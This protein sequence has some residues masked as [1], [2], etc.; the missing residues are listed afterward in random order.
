MRIWTRSAV[1]ALI[2]ACAFALAALC[3]GGVLDRWNGNVF[4]AVGL[5]LLALAFISDRTTA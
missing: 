4:Q 5:V 1:L 3:Y 2:A